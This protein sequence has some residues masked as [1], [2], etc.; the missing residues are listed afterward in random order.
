MAPPTIAI[1]SRPEAWAFSSPKPSNVNVNMVGNMIELNNPTTKI[2]HIETNP[3]E[4]MEI[5]I[6][7]IADSAKILNTLPGVIIFVR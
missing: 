7:T 2:D 1:Q 5:A 6:M 4:V 3:F